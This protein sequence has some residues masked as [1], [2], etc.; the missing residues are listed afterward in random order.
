MDL[1]PLGDWNEQ[2]ED[3]Q[4]PDDFEKEAEGWGPDAEFK[5]GLRT[6]SVGPDEDGNDCL[7]VSSASGG[8]YRY[9]RRPRVSAWF[10]S[11]RVAYAISYLSE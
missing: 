8:V 7:F 9:C 3:P 1:I 2:F 6:V 4:P 10:W 5:N 11:P